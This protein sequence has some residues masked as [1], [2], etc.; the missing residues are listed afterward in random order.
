M[1]ESVGI[2]LPRCLN[3][4]PKVHVLASWDPKGLGVDA[5]IQMNALFYGLGGSNC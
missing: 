2:L 1:H 3:E 5:S 4:C